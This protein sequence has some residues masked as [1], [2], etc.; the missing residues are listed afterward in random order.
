M[1][2]YRGAVNR[3]TTRFRDRV[4]LSMA[5][6][7][8]LALL[9]VPRVV[10]HDLD[11]VGP[12]VNAVLVFLPPLV[13]IGVVLAKR[14]S[15]PLVT[16]LAVGVVHGVLLAVTHQLLWSQAFEEPP[17]LGGNLAGV[18]S[19]GLEDVVVRAFAVGS[20]LVTGTLVGAVCGAVAWL[21]TRATRSR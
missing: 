20:S 2:P 3:N 13:W 7:V 16:L 10:A 6:T 14:V 8:G 17:G 12:T 4:G 9:G 5:A 11:L 1:P 21:L 19:P 15:D 18:L